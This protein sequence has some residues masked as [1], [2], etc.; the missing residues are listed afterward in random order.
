MLASELQIYLNNFPHILKFFDGIFA[1]NQIPKKLKNHHFIICN[2]DTSDQPGSHWYCFVNVNDS[3]Q[4]FDSLG[5]DVEKKR[6]ITSL[7]LISRSNVSELEFNS[8][9]VQASESISCGEFVLYFLI[10]RVYNKDMD[11]SELLNEIF[12]VDPNNNETT[13]IKFLEVHGQN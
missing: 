9:Q 11:F 3:L 12:D 13:V 4:C 1:A 6:F 2:T 8:T 5:V 7:P 10:H